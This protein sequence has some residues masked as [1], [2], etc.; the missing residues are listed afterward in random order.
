MAGSGDL[1]SPATAAPPTAA[2]L[3]E[4]YGVVVDA[5]GNL[6][7]ADRL[8]QRVRRVD[9][10]DRRDL[11]GRGQRLADLLG[12]RRAGPA[13][14]PGRAQRRRPR[15]GRADALH[16]RRGRPSDPQSSTLPR[17]RS[18]PSRDRAVGRH[19]GDGGPAARCSIWGARAVEVGPD[20][21]VYILEREGNTLRAV[22]PRTGLISTIAG[23]GAQGI[24]GRRR[25]R[26]GRRPSTGPRSWPSTERATSSSSTP[27]ITRSG[28]SITPRGRSGPWPARAKPADR[29]T[30]ARRRG[31]RLDRPHGVA[32]GPDGKIWIGDTNN[33]RIRV[34]DPRHPESGSVHKTRA[35]VATIR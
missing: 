11:D 22:D 28:S 19:E 12:G 25:P 18:A 15:R 5:A 27:R 1:A 26:Q 2:Q 4:P 20:G 24:L 35:R 6:Y 13:G 14:R 30:G 16:R 7:F 21:T 31:A 3:N 23:T 34:G 8:N 10:R 17:G 33:H 29:A 9:A 32:V